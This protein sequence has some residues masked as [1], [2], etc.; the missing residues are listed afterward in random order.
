MNKQITNLLI[1]HGEDIF[2]GGIPGLD[3]GP[4]MKI[5]QVAALAE[6]EGLSVEYRKQESVI[7]VWGGKE[8]EGVFELTTDNRGHV[9]LEAADAEDFHNS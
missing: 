6:K 7:Y 1:K 3:F 4:T 5:S 2:S 9:L 8:I